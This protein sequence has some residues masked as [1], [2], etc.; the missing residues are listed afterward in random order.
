[1]TVMQL[2]ALVVKSLVQR[3]GDRYRMLETVSEYAREQLRARGDVELVEQRHAERLIEAAE[4]VRGG[5]CYVPGRLE[6]PPGE[7]SM[8]WVK[9]RAR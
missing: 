4:A 5:R 7:C 6:S 9:R 2:E 8:L 3:R 1:M